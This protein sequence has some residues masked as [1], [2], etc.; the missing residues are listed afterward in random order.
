MG[1][2]SLPI[3]L[4]LDSESM[5]RSA[6][7]FR[8]VVKDGFLTTEV[9]EKMLRL[10]SGLLATSTDSEVINALGICFNLYI[11]GLLTKV[12]ISPIHNFLV[13]AQ[14]IRFLTKDDWRSKTKTTS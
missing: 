10:V 7:V 5:T 14:I 8:Q 6:F 2:R 13:V 4:E 1:I 9:G 11:S 3:M 12:K